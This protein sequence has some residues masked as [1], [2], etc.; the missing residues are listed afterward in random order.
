MVVPYRK[1]LSESCKNICGKMGIQVNFE[2]SN[3]VRRLLVAQKDKDKI[4]QKSG[5]IYRYRCDRFDCDEE[6]IE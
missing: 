2:G 3:T 5:A 6:Y 1:E 4:T